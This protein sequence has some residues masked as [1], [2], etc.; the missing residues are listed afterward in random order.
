MS[1][2]LAGNAKKRQSERKV[3]SCPGQRSPRGQPRAPR[4]TLRAPRFWGA[5][6]GRPTNGDA[7]WSSGTWLDHAYPSGTQ[8]MQRRA[9]PSVPACLAQPSRLA[10]FPPDVRQPGSSLPSASSPRHAR[11]APA[12]TVPGA[13]IQR[14]PAANRRLGHTHFQRR[15]CPHPFA[16]MPCMSPLTS[17]VL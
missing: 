3:A 12:G 17:E 5:G 4:S 1:I 14:T 6:Q 2:S 7:M 10:L 15:S 11:R 8:T 13:V 9:A 16:A